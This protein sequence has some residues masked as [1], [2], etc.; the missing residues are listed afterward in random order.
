MAI[1]KSLGVGKVYYKEPNA[2][3]YRVY[4]FKEFEAVINHFDKYP[5]ITKKQADYKLLKRVII[6]MKRKEHLTIE[7]IGKIVAL[8]AAMN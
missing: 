8:K 7:G 5:L 3:K 1:Q 6:I 2:V 4:N